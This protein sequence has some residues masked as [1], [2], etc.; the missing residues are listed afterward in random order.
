MLNRLYSGSNAITY[1]RRLNV[2]GIVANSQYQSKSILKEKPSLLQKHEKHLFGKNSRTILLTPSNPRNKRNFQ[3]PFP[4][5]SKSRRGR[6]A[7]I[8]EPYR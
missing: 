7:E 5:I 4:T 6:I 1:H 2:F 8:Q 3:N